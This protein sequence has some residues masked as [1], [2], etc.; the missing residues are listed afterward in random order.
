MHDLTR[1]S[2]WRHFAQLSV[3]LILGNILQ[4]FYNTIDAFVVGRFAGQEEFAAIGVAGTIMNLFLFAIVGACTGLSVLFAR[5]YGTADHDGLR[6]QHFTALLTG[7]TGALLL[8]GISLL[9]MHGILRLLQTPEELTGY[10]LTYLRWISIGY[11]FAFLYNMYAS[12][13]RASGNTMAALII[14]ACSVA[15]NLLLDLGFVAYLGW[16]IAGAA[17]ATFI[18]QCF[19]A[20]LCVGYLLKFQPEMTLRR[21]DCRI[22]PHLIVTTLQCSLVTAFHQASLYI[23]KMLIQGTVNTGG[24]EIIAA[25]TASTRIEGFANSIGDSGSA[26][27]SVLVSQ[28]YGAGKTDRVRN[29]FRYSLLITLC[30][31]ALCGAALYFGAPAAIALMQG[32]N[33]GVGFTEAVRYL[34]IVA[35]FYPL[36]FTGGSFT[37]LYNGLGKVTTTLI[38]SAGQILI[39]FVLSWVLFGNLALAAVA[40]A[41]G[42][43][44]TFC[45]LFWGV[46]TVKNRKKLFPT[47]E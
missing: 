47:K 39:R 13:L 45:N 27:T 1:G 21:K 14:L 18:T 17:C 44:W 9:G 28:N 43:G 15:A 10:I 32:T 42:L 30:A 6:R 41:T 25:Y 4:Q 2:L 31:G 35:L 23:G 40:G 37:G 7:L 26:T 38:G 33:T 11:P 34:R 19:S 20:L 16:G 22:D 46:L 8:C 24:T 5:Y 36:C 3:P 12:A 29:S